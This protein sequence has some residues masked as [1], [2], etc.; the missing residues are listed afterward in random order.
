MDDSLDGVLQPGTPVHPVQQAQSISPADSA[1]D[2]AADPFADPMADSFAGLDALSAQDVAKDTKAEAEALS[3]TDKAPP[4]ARE[5][6]ATGGAS[7][8]RFLS[9]SKQGFLEAAPPEAKSKPTHVD[10]PNSLSQFMRPQDTQAF[11][12]VKKSLAAA[13][14]LTPLVA[15]VSFEPTSTSSPA[16]RSKALMGMLTTVHRASA[17]TAKAMEGLTTETV[18]NWMISQLMAS[19]AGVVAQRWRQRHGISDR[20]DGPG[21]CCCAQ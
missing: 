5:L 4:L 3:Q 6:E 8:S 2:S 21:F 10:K 1:A 14:V 15:A 20:F 7:L 18:P 16:A 9:K 12:D 19:F 13:K 17:S 11:I